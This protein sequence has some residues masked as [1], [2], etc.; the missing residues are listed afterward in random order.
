MKYRVTTRGWIVFS[1]LGFLLIYIIISS[2]ASLTSQSDNNQ[3]P[4]IVS[5]EQDDTRNETASNEVDTEVD[6]T[7]QSEEESVSTTTEE[8]AD[9]AS[10]E[11][12]EDT[13]DE[14]NEVVQEETVDLERMTTVLFEKNVAD[15]NVSYNNELDDWIEILR[16]HPELIII[17]EGHINGYPNYVDGEFGLSLAQDRANIVRDYL[18]AGGVFENQIETINCGSKKQVDM[19]HDM[20]QHYLNRRTIIYFKKP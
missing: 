15:L 7:N 9:T 3:E 10:T 12:N 6:E 1:V 14:E 11:D 5:E 20:S 16:K 17:I 8:S 2:L 13:S 4:N 19:G 18:I